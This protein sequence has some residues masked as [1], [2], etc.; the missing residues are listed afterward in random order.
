MSKVYV[1][2]IG[3]LIALDCGE[4]VSTATVRTI[5]ARRP[6]GTTV[7]WTSFADGTDGIAY[8]TVSGDLSMVGLWTFQ[9]YVELPSGWKGPGDSVTLM[10]YGAHG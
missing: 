9:A 6:D 1:G 4:D 7:D 8:T 2:S 5:K 10:V 3:T